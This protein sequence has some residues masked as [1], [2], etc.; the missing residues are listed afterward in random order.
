MTYPT[1]RSLRAL[2]LLASGAVLAAALIAPAG[3]HVTNPGHLWNKHLK[4]MAKNLFYTKGQSDKRFLGAN[5]K[6]VSAAHADNADNAAHAEDAD[7]AAHADDADTLDGLDSIA[8]GRTYSGTVSRPG[9]ETTLTDIAT[10]PGLGAVAFK[11]ADNASQV[12]LKPNSPGWTIFDNGTT[13]EPGFFEGEDTSNYDVTNS[14]RVV[15]E[16]VNGNPHFTV[17]ITNIYGIGAADN[18][19]VSWRA[20]RY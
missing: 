8:F 16:T 4:S 6:A 2:A 14:D 20:I 9:S 1:R 19:L 12:S 15:F 18:C 7:N 17:T 11:C 5:D 3:A 10:I 13:A